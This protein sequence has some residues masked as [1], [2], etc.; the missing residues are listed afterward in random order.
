MDDNRAVNK[1]FWE[2]LLE[3][4]ALSPFLAKIKEENSGLQLR[5]RGN[6]T[7][8][9]ITIYYNNHMVWRISKHTHGYKVEVSA[10]HAKGSR[11]DELL[12]QLQREPLCFITSSKH[13]Q[14]YPYVIRESFDNRFVDLTYN[15]MVSAIR[16]FFG[17]EKYREKRIQQELFDA[18]TDSQ[19]GLYAYDLE[20]KQRGGTKF[21]NEPDM[22]AVRYS[23]GSPQSIV[24][25]EVKSKW[26]A[27][28]DGTSGLTKH[29]DGMNDYIKESPYLIN[30]KHEAH[31]IISA[32]KGLNL[33]NPPKFVPDPE[34]IKSFEMMIILTDTAVDYYH[35]HDVDIQK[36][37][38]KQEY[39]CEIVKWISAKTFETLYK[40]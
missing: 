17:S 29:L 25:I 22:L 8:E 19:D 12:E 35:T 1:T 26:K 30:R 40:Y 10:N 31:D 13:S 32:Y 28:E 27:C 20:F 37:I 24:L 4:G 23:G 3:N 21:E 6:N 2:A 18:M 14:S 7:P 36:Y 11:K 9:A 38:Q 16:D 34:D 5:F 39:S 33:H 15:M